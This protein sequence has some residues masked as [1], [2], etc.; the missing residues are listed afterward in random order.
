MKIADFGIAKIVGE[1]K[2]DISLTA[3][4]AALG[5][6]HYMAPEQFEKPATVDHRADIYSLGVVFYEMLTGEL[7]I[8]RFS[9]PSQRTPVDPRVDDVVMRTLEKERE[10]RFQSA[11]EMKTNVEHLTES[12]AGSFKG[13]SVPPKAAAG[14]SGPGGTMVI[15][16]SAVTT[17]VPAWSLKAVWG[18]VLVGLSSLPMI[19]LLAYAGAYHGRL[20]GWELILIIAS[21]T[22]SLP[23]I[24]GTIL[25]W[26]GLNDIRAHAGQRHGLP[27]AVFAA[28]AWPDLILLIIG[29]ALPLKLMAPTDG[30]GVRIFS[31]ILM[32]PVAVGTITFAIW[33]VYAAV[34][35]GAN[36]PAV[37]R[38]GKLKWIFAMLMLG[39]LGFIALS[40]FNQVQRNRAWAEANE[41]RLPPPPV[42]VAETNAT[43]WIRFTFTAVELREVRGVRW[44]A[45]DYLD[46]VHGECQKSFPWETTIPGFR[47][48]TR[49]SEFR[50][51]AKDGSPAVR[52]Q[53]IEYRM[54]D[55]APRDQLEGLRNMLAKELIQKSFRL[56]LGEEKRLF[57]FLPL[58]GNL[59]VNG[60][61][62]AR[63]KVVPPLKSASASSQKSEVGVLRLI[64]VRDYQ[65]LALMR[66]ES[67]PR[68]P[69]HEIV[70]RFSGP[71][72]AEAVALAPKATSGPHVIPSPNE[73]MNTPVDEPV[74]G[75]DPV[76][77]N[78]MPTASAIRV[79]CPGDYSFAFVLPDE[80]LAREA[81]RQIKQSLAQPVSLVSGQ[82][83]LL[84][85]IGERKAWLEVQPF[86][87]VNNKLAFFR[88][89]GSPARIPGS[90]FVESA[91]ITIPAGYEL[92]LTGRLTLDN[93]NQSEPVFSTRLKSER[94]EPRIYWIT[95]YSLPNPQTIDG[96]N[97]E[98]WELMIHD[99]LGHEL[100]RMKAPE[101]LKSGWRRRWV[102]G[103]RTARAGEPMYQQLFEKFDPPTVA[104]R[105]G[106][107]VTLEMTIR[108][109]DPPDR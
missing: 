53:R 58:A 37:E 4:G 35:W 49:T 105:R 75:G 97:T 102:G 55:S 29:L 16:P 64:A 24:A 9:P 61:L 60:G 13:A 50:T 38:R 100:F 11:G 18:A 12:G 81:D 84:F 1:D 85:K 46:D 41:D 79:P 39:G 36:Q 42:A 63:I 15:N 82:Q 7:P 66:F 80:N 92:N 8:G 32:L 22:F 98:D 88:R 93:V 94:D 2:P 72:L 96:G 48:E 30:N 43:P 6:P 62:T 95:W 104:N 78:Q 87:P 45:I 27:L 65:N 31:A 83:I 34:R 86:H 14:E 25:G 54:P 10:K 19:V 73:D 5:T 71:E 99:E 51:E 108:R 47:A 33:T 3:T 103:V 26:M 74:A 52:H 20:G 57:S 23:A 40:A 56:E 17:A 101:E 70:V 59:V 90:N 107:Y 44:L 69:L 21:L 91:V 77:T 89:G 106:S 76:G 67:L 68:H 28:L 109:L